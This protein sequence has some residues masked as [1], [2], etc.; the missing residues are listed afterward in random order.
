MCC[1]GLVAACVGA[2]AGELYGGVGVPGLMLGFAQPVSPSITLRADFSTLGSRTANGTEEGISYAGSLKTNR[3]GAFADW[4][5]SSG[6]FRLTGGITFNRFGLDLT[7]RPGAGQSITIGDVTYPLLAADDRLD[8]SVK[9]PDTTPYVGIGYGHRM[10]K[11]WGFVADLGVSI[12]KPTVTAVA[13]GTNLGSIAGI[14]AEIAKEVAELR[15]GVG[16]VSVLPQLSV[17]LSYSF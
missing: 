9:F 4:F 16:K 8:V 11:G 2:Q 17:A 5:P 13:S 14:Q 10:G 1:F 6:G 3:V 15:D 12:G 7:A